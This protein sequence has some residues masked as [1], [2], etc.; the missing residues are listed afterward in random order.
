MRIYSSEFVNH[1]KTNIENVGRNHN[2]H[3]L[4]TDS[5]QEIVMQASWYKMRKKQHYFTFNVFFQLM[6]ISVNDEIEVPAISEQLPVLHFSVTFTIGYKVLLQNYFQMV[7]NCGFAVDV[8]N[9]IVM[10]S[11]NFAYVTKMKNAALY[12]QSRH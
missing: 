4:F 5:F 3:L 1:G 10:F 12:C 9:E 6:I 2:D 8:A 11:L 7:M